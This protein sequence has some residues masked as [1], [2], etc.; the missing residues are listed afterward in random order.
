[1]YGT[2]RCKCILGAFYPQTVLIAVSLI[3]AQSAQV[4]LV[5]ISPLMFYA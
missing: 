2:F 3:L 1:M 5:F 4:R